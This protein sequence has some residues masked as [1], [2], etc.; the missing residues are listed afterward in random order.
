MSWD[1]V[2]TMSSVPRPRGDVRKWVRLILHVG[3]FACQILSLIIRGQWL[4]KA[5]VVPKDVFRRLC[6]TEKQRPRCCGELLKSNPLQ[7]IS[8]AL[9]LGLA[10]GHRMNFAVMNTHLYYYNF[11]DSYLNSAFPK[12]TVVCK[13]L[14]TPGQTSHS[15]GTGTWKHFAMFLEP[16]P[17]LW[18]AQIFARRC[19][20]YR[21]K[22][23]KMDRVKPVFLW[24]VSILNTASLFWVMQSC[25]YLTALLH[26][27][28]FP[29]RH[30]APILWIAEFYYSGEEDEYGDSSF[31]YI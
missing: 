30:A 24:H 3:P 6:E 27:P 10:E 9:D 21:A 13:H 26:I 2:G 25:Q 29:D 31:S 16:S 15:E 18:G 8:I 1:A 11:E 22:K 5:D 20:W 23:W 4:H 19:R 14:R 12:H 7:R 17:A 28:C